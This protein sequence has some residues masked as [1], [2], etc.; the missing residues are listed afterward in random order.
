M[1][2]IS[3]ATVAAA[4]LASVALAANSVRGGKQVRDWSA[5]DAV[6]E[7]GVTNSVYPGCSAAVMDATG[8]VVYTRGVGQFTYGE[9][10]PRMCLPAGVALW[11]C[12]RVCVC[13]CE[14]VHGHAH[15][16]VT[17]RLPRLA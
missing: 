14:C 12:A 10:P 1:A 17:S 13:V 7:A 11:L 15:T 9:A 5:V 16:C 8:N 3:F 4:A 2:R 6:L